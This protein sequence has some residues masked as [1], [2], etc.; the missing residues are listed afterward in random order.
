M[1]LSAT[2]ILAAALTAA[3]HPSVGHNHAHLHRAVAR[4]NKFVRYD[5]PSSTPSASSS[6]A[7]PS[8]SDDETYE[9]SDDDSSDSS[10]SS[11]GEKKEFCSG[12]KKRATA[13]DISYEGNTG[14]DDD[15]GCNIMKIDC[16]TADLYDFSAEFSST[17]DEYS[18][19]AFNKIGPDGGINGFWHSALDFSVK[20]GDKVCIAFD[21]NSQGGIACGA[22]SDGPGK[23]E[24]GQ[25]AGTWC[26]FDW[27]SGKNGGQS[28]A[29]VSTIVADNSEDKEVQDGIIS[30]AIEA[31]GKGTCSKLSLENPDETVE[32]YRKGDEDLDGVG[33]KGYTK[34]QLKVSL[35]D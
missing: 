2:L 10:D 27:G 26:E 28:G 30:M 12:N 32:V 17:G 21:D 9:E 23:T 13:Y 24:A 15:W 33:C 11:S 18:C 8:A 14:T 3:A 7:E 20:G 19:S 29:D 5:Q 35:G 6:S 22:G 34:G 4:S 16:G 1:H 25:L 31:P